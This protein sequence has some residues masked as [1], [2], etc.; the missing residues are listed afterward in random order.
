MT[1]DYL[2]IISV[3]SPYDVYR[4]EAI[5]DC[6]LKAERRRLGAKSRRS[7]REI[8]RCQTT[9]NRHIRKG[10]VHELRAV[11]VFVPHDGSRR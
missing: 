10:L 7:I 11:T 9:R 8:K 2:L 1:A 5:E 3:G 6:R 4:T